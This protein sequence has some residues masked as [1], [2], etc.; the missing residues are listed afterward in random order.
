MTPS[1]RSRVFPAMVGLILVSFVTLRLV[2]ETTV[3]RPEEVGLSAERLTRITDMVKRHIAAGEISGGVTFVARQGKIAHFEATGA[4]DIETKKPMSKDAVFRIASMTKPVVGVA[5]MMMMEEGKLRITDPVSKYIPSFKDLKVAVEEPRQGAQNASGPPKYYAVPAAREI[6]I[7]DL[8]THVSGL[9]SGPMSSASIGGAEIAR[10]PTEGLSDYV[11]RLGRS[12]LE[13]QPGT[14]WTYSPGAGFDTLGHVVEITS[15]QPLDS[16]LRERIFEPLGMKDVSFSPPPALE[17]RL[18]TA[19]LL[20]PGSRARKDPNPNRMQSKVYFSGGGGLVAT[21]EEYAKFAQ[22]LLNGGELNGKRLLSPRTVAYMASVH[23]PDTLP[24]RTPGE[25][26]GLSVRVVNNAAAS[27]ARVSDGSFGWSG[28]FGTH[29]WVDP[30]ESLIAIMM[31]QT[32]ARDMR[33][34]FEN[35]VMQAIIR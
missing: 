25:G 26:Y 33:P 9:G 18:V 1:M 31:I 3:V 8:L 10:K 19:Y 28:A 12:V 15:G 4:T 11:P 14:R 16:F 20:G 30:K 6:T 17:P 24:G 13:F 32:P 22:M 35:A 2:A 34:E 27:G 21:A 29:F 7:R 5:V 23:V